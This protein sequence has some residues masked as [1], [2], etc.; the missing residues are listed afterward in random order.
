MEQALCSRMLA[1]RR[2]A[3]PHCLMLKWYVCWMAGSLQAQLPPSP[4]RGVKSA[5][6]LP[7]LLQH[8]EQHL[9][10][11]C[12]GTLCRACGSTSSC[13]GQLGLSSGI[14][15]VSVVKIMGS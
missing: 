14:A 2:P 1:Q 15:Q 5:W 4:G 12:W 9:S 6:A 8:P 13:C 10:C 7:T 11:S 3:Q